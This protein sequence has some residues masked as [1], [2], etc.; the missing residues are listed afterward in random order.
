VRHLRLLP[1]L[2]ALINKSRGDEIPFVS[3]SVPSLAPA[4]SAISITPIPAPVQGGDSDKAKR[5]TDSVCASALKLSV[6]GRQQTLVAHQHG[7]QEL[8][9]RNADPTGPAGRAA[10]VTESSGRD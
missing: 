3:P 9:K 7:I 4:P 5:F 1:G 8:E 10:G 2:A 6:G